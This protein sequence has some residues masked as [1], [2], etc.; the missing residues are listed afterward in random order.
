MPYRTAAGGFE[1]ARS[2]GHVPTVAHPLV[3]ETL[4]R[5]QM[6]AERREG[7]VSHQRQPRGPGD[8]FATDS[9]GPLDDRD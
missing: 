6:P 1:R 8:P 2:L 9:R 5:Y 7:R 3:Q 4:G